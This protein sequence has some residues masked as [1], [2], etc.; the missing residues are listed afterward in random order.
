MMVK[1]VLEQEGPLRMIVGFGLLISSLLTYI[2]VLLFAKRGTCPPANEEPFAN[3]VDDSLGGILKTIQRVSGTLLQP[4]TWTDRI[5]MY[6][7]SPVDLARR[8]LKSQTKAE[9]AAA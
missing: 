2:I 9:D 8:Y 3:E 6:N 1:R 7:L 4:S 5:E